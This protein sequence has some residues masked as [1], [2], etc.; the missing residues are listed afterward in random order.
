[1]TVFLFF[2]VTLDTL[3]VAGIFYL[4]WAF[5]KR[6]ENFA[7]KLGTFQTRIEELEGKHELLDK[8]L[9]SLGDKVAEGEEAICKN[10]EVVEN[11]LAKL[12]HEVKDAKRPGPK[13]QEAYTAAERVQKIREQRQR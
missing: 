13:I 8:R 12:N 5:L 9:T 6:L 7:D 1:M 4:I 3:A 10:F 11:S 2:L